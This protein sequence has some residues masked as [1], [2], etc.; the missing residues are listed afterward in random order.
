MFWGEIICKPQCFPFLFHFAV[1]LEIALKIK[2][3]VKNIKLMLCLVEKQICKYVKR[4]GQKG[5]CDHSKFEGHGIYFKI[6]N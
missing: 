3:N 4:L 1:N 5:Y 6:N 2:V